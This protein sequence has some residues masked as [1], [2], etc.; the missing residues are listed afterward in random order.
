MS[1][2]ALLEAQKI[3]LESKKEVENLKKL[4]DASAKSVAEAK[5][6][7]DHFYKNEK[8]KEETDSK[9]TYGD[10]NYWHN[11]FKTEDAF[12]WYLSLPTPDLRNRHC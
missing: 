12:E 5:G 2:K 9:D 4:R 1:L 11:R 3:L 7:V 10:L 6:E 8:K